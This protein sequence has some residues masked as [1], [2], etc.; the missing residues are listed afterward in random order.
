MAR[1]VQNPDLGKSKVEFHS[2]G[3]K[4]FGLFTEI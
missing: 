3:H 4:L 1:N 2:R